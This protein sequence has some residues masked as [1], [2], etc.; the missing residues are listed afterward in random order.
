MSRPRLNKVVQ[1]P[2]LLALRSAYRDAGRSVVWTNGCFDLMHAG[3]VRSLH[4]AADLGD[5]LVVGLNSDASV[6]R[7]KGPGRPVL[8]EAERAEL[9][10]ALECVDH[11]LVFPDDE[12]S[13]VLRQLR[14]DVHCKGAE[15]APPRGRPLPE[16]AVVESYGGRV[17]FL[18]LVEGLSTTELLR[19]VRQL[20]EEGA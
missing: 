3:H 5:V 12:P 7:L 9:L 4:A 15:Y 1:I 2:A 6:R 14:P 10:A 17:A 20:S 19:R 8:P 16:R 18:P 13:N 11:V